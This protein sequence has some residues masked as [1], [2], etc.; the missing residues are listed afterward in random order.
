MG[1]VTKM[2]IAYVVALLLLDEPF[3]APKES[4]LQVYNQIPGVNGEA[5]QTL[6]YTRSQFHH[7]F[8]YRWR[9]GNWIP[10][11]AMPLA[12]MPP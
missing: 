11:G 12:Q 9:D 8:C 1:A 10:Q 2:V 5:R 3:I 6:N 7:H 4:F